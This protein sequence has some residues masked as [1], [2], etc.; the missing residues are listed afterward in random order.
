M[1]D[2][3]GFKIFELEYF[4]NNDFVLLWQFKVLSASY[5]HDQHKNK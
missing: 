1:F 3:R 2:I 5:C 4:D